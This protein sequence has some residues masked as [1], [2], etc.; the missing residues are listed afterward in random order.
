MRVL[1]HA[2]GATIGGASRHLRSLAPALDRLETGH[3]YFVLARPSLELSSV[4]SVIVCGVQA[5][6]AT[7]WVRRLAFDLHRVNRIAAQLRADV[8]VSLT[9]FGPLATEIPHV[10]FQRNALYYGDWIG[11]HAPLATRLAV[12]VRRRLAYE[13][14]KRARL[15]VTPSHAM[16]AMIRRTYPALP[17]SRMRTLYHACDFGGAVEPLPSLL[18]RP[19]ARQGLKL[20]YPTHAAAHKGF[21]LLIDAL[22]M[23]ARARTDWT[24]FATL[25][26]ADWP[27]GVARLRRTVRDRGLEDRFV[28]LGRVAEANMPALYRACDLLVYPSL[29]ES[30]G[31]PMVEAMA[32]G[33]PVVAS[34]S[35]VNREICAGAAAYFQPYDAEDA[36]RVLRTCFDASV[37]ARLATAGQVRAAVFPGNW[38][39][40][41]RS[42]VEMIGSV[43]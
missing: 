31:F 26:D 34:G 18:A 17:A 32:S 14:M 7:S 35:D 19:L 29:V 8:I 41:A 16:A 15:V 12:G 42:F 11:R 21:D 3:E 4:G 1:I 28:A 6:E 22:T 9:N 30:F 5:S 43:H 2:L 10:L 20:L 23:L 36:A 13:G 33:L 40:Y 25:D 27:A 38:D 24:L 37:R 39:A